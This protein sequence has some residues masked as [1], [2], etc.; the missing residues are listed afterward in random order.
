[1]NW[2]DTILEPDTKTERFDH[3]QITM[4]GTASDTPITFAFNDGQ[5]ATSMVVGSK[6]RK[7]QV[8]PEV[9]PTSASY[10][11]IITGMHG[12]TYIFWANLTHFSLQEFPMVA[13]SARIFDD[14]MMPLWYSDPGAIDGEGE[15]YRLAVS[16][17]LGRIV[18]L[19]HRSTAFIPDSLRD[20]VLLF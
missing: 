9:G 5:N 7:Q 6:V 18:A 10:S 8:G 16:I 3:D 15:P 11:C 12:P 20:S 17:G 1:V 14:K 4:N 2:T 13:S 19:Y